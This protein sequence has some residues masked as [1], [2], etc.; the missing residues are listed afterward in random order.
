MKF[1]LYSML[2]L[3]LLAQAA[4]IAQH[5]AY[6]FNRIDI[7]QGL[8]NNQ[9]K[10]IVKDSRGFLWF[11]TMSGLNRYD[12]YQFKI[13]RYNPRDTVSLSDNYIQ[14]IF[15]GPDKKIWVDT[16]NGMNVLDPV[17]ET[18]DRNMAAN[19][20]QLSLPLLP[21][22]SMLRDKQGHC[23]LLLNGQY[24]YRYTD[25][26]KAAVLVYQLPQGAAPLS[27]FA[28][29]GAGGLWLVHTNGLLE[30]IDD[31]SGKLLFT[32]DAL[33][34]KMNRELLNY[35][36]FTDAQEELWL[37]IAAGARGV[38]HFVPGTGA[39]EIIDKDH[40]RYRLNNNIVVGVLQDN[41]NNIWISTDHG[42]VNVFN[43]NNLTMQYLLNNTQDSKSLAE[44][45]ISTSYKDAEGFIWIGTYKHGVSYFHSNIIKF[46]LL[47]NNPADKA[48]LQFND[49]NDF[50]EDAK[51]NIWIGTN[52]GGL[53]CY[54][55]SKESFTQYQHKAGNSNSLSNDVIV[56]LH[57]D[58]DGKLWIGTYFG[59]MDCFDGKTFTHYRYNPADSSSLPDDRVFEIMEDSQRNLWVGTFSGGLTRLDRNKN[60]FYHYKAYSPN[61]VHAFYISELMEDREGNI[62]V[63]SSNGID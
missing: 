39:L 61:S 22:T 8:S 51:G 42:G 25:G 1:A 18:V 6:Q 41:D 44:N 38:F 34:N 48:S 31:R 43:K 15:E 2:I 12:G 55:R 57:I 28:H 45:S 26:S 63:G 9:V 52:G 37:Y 27:S 20:K 3:L 13:F 60:S 54:N 30:K 19:M 35:A 62:W 10:G 40:P 47:R 21:I 16:H 50:A 58:R 56:T 24:I 14:R 32:A 59:G 46:P 49:I 29:N 5:P 36:L 33:A 53:I 17:T 7:S 23:W 4:A 11:A